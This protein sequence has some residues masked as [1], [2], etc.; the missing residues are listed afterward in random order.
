MNHDL[1]TDLLERRAEDVA[2]RAGS[3]PAVRR[4]AARRR[5]HARTAV[6]VAGVTVAGATFAAVRSLPDHNDRR[7]VAAD[8]TGVAAASTTT[9]SPLMQP[10]QRDMPV[11]DDVRDLQQRL[12]D[13]GFDPGPVD[14]LFGESTQQAVWA[15]EG[16][17]LGRTYTEQTG[18]VDN[19]VWQAL[20]TAITV[21]PRRTDDDDA[22]HIEIYLDLQVAVVFT[23]DAPTLIT[24]TSSGSGETWCELLRYDT[25]DQGR[26]IDP[27]IEK[28]MCGVA[29]TPGGVFKI[30]RRFDGNRATPLGGMFNPLYFNYGIALYGAHNVPAQPVS[31]GGIRI[32]MFIAER[33]PSLVKNGTPVYVFDGIT[34]PEDVS[35][36]DRVPTFDYPNPD[37]T[38]TTTAS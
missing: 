14:G 8:T 7:V 35:A 13:L 19:A 10:L 22:T 1:L 26:M 37:S 36:K 17:A 3:L 6:G 21:Q 24:H 28:D 5:A 4:R 9:I 34:E 23:D 15:F 33:L 2:L 20:H 16:L 25:D 30:Y 32:P 27:P 29:T 18:V 12:T 31:H 38:T 11:S